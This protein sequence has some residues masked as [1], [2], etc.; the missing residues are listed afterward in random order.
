MCVYNFEN[1]VHG[2][3]YA[4]EDEARIL[5]VLEHIPDDVLSLTG[6]FVDGFISFCKIEMRNGMVFSIQ[7]LIVTY[8]D[9]DAEGNTHSIDASRNMDE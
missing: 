6:Q 2:K 3:N 5:L 7:D 4:Y 8:E 9:V 1:T